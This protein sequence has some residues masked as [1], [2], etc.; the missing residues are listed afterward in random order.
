MKQTRRQSLGG[1][2]LGALASGW[3]F[4]QSKPEA[5]GRS[6]AL[7]ITEYFEYASAPVPPQGRWR[8]YGIG[9]PE[10]VLR[11]VYH[12]NAARLLNTV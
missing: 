11:K 10:P 3:A 5:A 2:V 7:D 12:D 8:I 4:G 1:A 6:A 9:L